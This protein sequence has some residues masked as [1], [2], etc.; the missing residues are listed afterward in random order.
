MLPPLG[1]QSSFRLSVL[2]LDILNLEDVAVT[3]KG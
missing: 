2:T 1:D 3:E